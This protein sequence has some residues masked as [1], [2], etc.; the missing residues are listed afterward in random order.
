MYKTLINFEPSKIIH[1][2]RTLPHCHLDCQ[3]PIDKSIRNHLQITFLFNL[4]S[5]PH[6]AS[7]VAHFSDIA[8]P[9]EALFCFAPPSCPKVVWP[10]LSCSFVAT[11]WPELCC[12]VQSSSQAP[13]APVSQPAGHADLKTVFIQLVIHDRLQSHQDVCHFYNFLLT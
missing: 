13:Q 10:R 8:L 1:S 5:S 4:P 12:P 2:S 6:P 7:Q 11:T 9:I 3:R